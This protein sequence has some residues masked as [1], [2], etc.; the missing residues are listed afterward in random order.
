VSTTADWH[1]FGGS[2]VCLL[3]MKD[4][5]FLQEG[6]DDWKALGQ[7]AADLLSVGAG[8]SYIG[9][10]FAMLAY[11]LKQWS[12]FRSVPAEAIAMLKACRDLLDDLNHSWTDIMAHHQ[13]RASNWVQQAA[14]AAA[15]CLIV[16]DKCAL[17]RWASISLILKGSSAC[18][19]SL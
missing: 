13:E 11:A 16:Q 18:V 17:V 4:G 3:Q 2:L 1:C 15:E 5:S 19:Q 10:A 12:A 6:E 8:V 9:P 7:T 14:T